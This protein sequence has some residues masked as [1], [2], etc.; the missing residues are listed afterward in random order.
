MGTWKNLV[1]N[2][3]NVRGF[4]SNPALSSSRSR[5]VS[6]LVTALC[7]PLVRMR[8]SLKELILKLL[9]KKLV[10]YSIHDRFFK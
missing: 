7:K 10:V 4:A 5:R 8:K 3:E 2:T 6:R 9:L 1:E